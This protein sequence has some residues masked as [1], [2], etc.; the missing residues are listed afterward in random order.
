MTLKT[1]RTIQFSEILLTFFRRCREFISYNLMLIFRSRRM[2]DSFS[3]LEI[4]QQIYKLVVNKRKTKLTI[5]F[6]EILPTFSI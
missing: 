6:S 5:Q 3:E 4:E 2:K 1:S